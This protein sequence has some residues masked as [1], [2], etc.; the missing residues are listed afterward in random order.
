MPV[1]SYACRGSNRLWTRPL[2]RY[3]RSSLPEC[4][5]K[6]MSG[7]ETTQDRTQTKDTPS[8]RLQIKISDP[9]GDR[10]LAAGLEGMDSTDHATA[11]DINV[12][13]L[14]WSKGIII[15]FKYIIFLIVTAWKY[16]SLIKLNFEIDFRLEW[17]IGS[18][19]ARRI[20]STTKI[21]QS[22]CEIQYLEPLCLQFL[23]KK[24]SWTINDDIRGCV[25]EWNEENCVVS[26]S[27]KGW[28]C[29]Q[30]VIENTNTD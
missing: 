29:C 15:Y 24:W 23:L 13:H 25:S 11:T 4:V 30:R 20:I 16:L 1:G 28:L 18:S 8:P 14:A 5:V 7:P 9:A 2:D 22:E 19:F 12:I 27:V 10:T 3:T 26:N 21:L 17:L 6:A